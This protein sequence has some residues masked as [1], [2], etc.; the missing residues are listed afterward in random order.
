M[1]ASERPKLSFNLTIEILVFSSRQLAM[2]AGA[3]I[4]VSIS[5]LRFLSFQGTPTES[6]QPG[7]VK[8]QSHN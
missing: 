5:Q 6:L 8:F 4:H 3:I 1:Q 7:R 2:A